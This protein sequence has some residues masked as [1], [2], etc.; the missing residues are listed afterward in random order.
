M[1]SLL[2]DDACCADALGS[3]CNQE[4]TLPL[5]RGVDV[6]AFVRSVWNIVVGNVVNLVVLEEV[7]GH[8]PGAVLDDLIY[9]FAVP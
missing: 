7:W 3:L 9:P 6:V 1:V 5:D 2:R 4:L 8:D